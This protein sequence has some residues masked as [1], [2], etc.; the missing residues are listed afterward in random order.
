MKLIGNT[1]TAYKLIIQ[2]QDGCAPATCDWIGIPASAMAKDA[3]DRAIMVSEPPAA[4]R[5]MLSRTAKGKVAEGNTVCRLRSTNLL[6]LALMRLRTPSGMRSLPDVLACAQKQSS[7]YCQK[8]KMFVRSCL[9][10]CALH[11][12]CNPVI[13]ADLCSKQQAVW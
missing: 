6:W 9:H 2:H 3:A 10:S 11:L 1:R 13:C 5:S 8:L 4:M 12:E 7:A